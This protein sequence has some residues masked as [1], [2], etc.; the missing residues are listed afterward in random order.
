MKTNRTC[1]N[2]YWDSLE[3][4]RLSC[5]PVYCATNFK[6][7]K[8][9]RFYVMSCLTLNLYS[10]FFVRPSSC[11]LRARMAQDSAYTNRWSRS[12][13][14]HERKNTTH[15]V[16]RLNMSLITIYLTIFLLRRSQ[17]NNFYYSYLERESYTRTHTAHRHR[18]S[19]W[20]IWLPRKWFMFVFL[21]KNSF[22]MITTL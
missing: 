22:R 17:W 13:Y 8:N 21:L 11:L 6:K 16:G 14:T 20:I 2:K 4:H 15:F 9:T 12:E 7:G 3:F 1:H 5:Q 18:N 10:F 19:C